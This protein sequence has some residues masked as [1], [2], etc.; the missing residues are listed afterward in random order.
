MC[1]LLFI[2]VFILI[3]VFVHD[4]IQFTYIYVY[5]CVYERPFPNAQRVATQEEDAYRTH[6]SWNTVR[7]EVV[8]AQEWLTEQSSN[9]VTLHTP[10]P[11]PAPSP[12]SLSRNSLAWCPLLAFTYREQGRGFQVFAKISY[13]LEIQFTCI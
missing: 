4:H 2:Y 10:R 8:S 1:T 5:T 12:P 13:D 9:N 7:D 11:P 6:E 3:H